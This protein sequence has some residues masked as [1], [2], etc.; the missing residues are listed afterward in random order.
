MVK[1]KKARSKKKY[2]KLATMGEI[3][4]NI[5]NRL[6]SPIDA[7]NSFLNLALQSTGEDSQSRQFLL[8]SKL[9]LRRLSVL[10]KRLEHYAKKMEKEFYEVSGK[11]D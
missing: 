4:R 2:D 1:S 9:G 7:T 3:S 6:Y 10:I 8:E 11:R 5:I